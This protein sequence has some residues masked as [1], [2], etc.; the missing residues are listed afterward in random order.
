MIDHGFMCHSCGQRHEGLPFSYGTPAPAYWRDDLNNDE[1]SVLEDEICIIQAQHYFVRARLVIPVLDADAV[2]EWGVWVSL[3]STSFSRM[4]DH[5]TTPGR[6]QEPAYFGWLS[7]E[8]PAYP[9]ETLNLK[10][11]VHTEQVGTR[12]HI[13]L[14]PTDHPLSVEQRNGISVKRVQEI[15]ELLL[16]HEG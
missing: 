3:S 7:T 8:L 1:R 15:A 16:H 12:P 2:F 11:K 10:T 6:E 5:W 14:E 13:V 4:L 9:I